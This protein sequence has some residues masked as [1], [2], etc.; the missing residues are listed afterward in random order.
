V[1]AADADN[2]QIIDGA[3]P[4]AADTVTV[5]CAMPL[6]T[7]NTAWTTG[8]V[9]P[10][11]ALD[12]VPVTVNWLPLSTGLFPPRLMLSR[13]AANHAWNSVVIRADC[14]AAPLRLKGKVL[15]AAAMALCRFA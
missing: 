6:T 10:R 7:E 8:L 13:S 11:N 2:G 3:H 1:R 15:A 5:T 9:F 14:N 4:D 12:K